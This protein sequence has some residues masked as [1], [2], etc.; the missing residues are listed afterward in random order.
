VRPMPDGLR[1]GVD[2]GALALARRLAWALIVLGLAAAAYLLWP[3]AWGGQ[4]G[5]IMVAGSRMEPTLK[6]GDLVLM[7]RSGSYSLGD[8]VAYASP[9]GTLVHRIVGGS[10]QEGFLLQ[11][12]NRD[13]PDP[14]RPLPQELMGALWLR[15]PSGAIPLTYLRQPLNLLVLV[16]SL[17]GLLLLGAGAA[18]RRRKGP[19][20]LTAEPARSWAV[21]LG[22]PTL[23]PALVA[24]GALALL[25][26]VA[27]GSTVYGFLRPSQQGTVQQVPLYEHLGRFQYLL[28]MQPST[29]YPE[30]QLGPVAPATEG[31]GQ[32]APPNPIY[33]RLAR[34]LLVS[35][36]YQ[37]QAPDQPQ[38]SGEVS[39]TLLLSA[40][41]DAWSK[42]LAV[43]PPQPFSG[44]SAALEMGID[45]EQV[46]A[47]IRA[48][49]SETGFRA[50]S[51]SLTFLPLVRLQG[52]VAGESV[53]DSFQAP[54]TVRLEG[55]Q[56]VQERQLERRE[57]RTVSQTLLRPQSVA[58]AGLKVPV[59]TWRW[60]SLGAT[61]LF[62]GLALAATALALVRGKVAWAEL[63]HHS[64]IVEVQSPPRQEGEPWLAV[65]SLGDLA[66]LARLAEGAIFK[67]RHNGGALYFVKGNSA[68]YYWGSNPWPHRPRRH[69]Q[70]PQDQ[71]PV[72]LHRSAQG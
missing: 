33:L 66:R 60:A 42:T 70:A 50:G 72:A 53:D 32:V 55:G 27:L 64:L 12:D 3:A 39:A 5:Y 1:W 68:T 48:V 34:S 29:L 71:Q 13:T 8:V 59:S 22:E 51:Y 37:M 7:R 20:P 49:E 65:A 19:R 63:L 31:N 41:R 26:L 24:V 16:A 36:R 30:G 69:P 28:A 46:Q 62:L 54:F 15:V 57:A 21:S 14:Y 11:G 38:V 40:G 25:G 43:L 67:W 9:A 44:D 35:Y 58:L 52:Q 6:E 18:R 17:A 23:A 61:L 10:P 2:P 47:I 56:L 4:V 45:L